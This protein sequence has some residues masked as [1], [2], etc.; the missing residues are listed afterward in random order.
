[1]SK[2]TEYSDG[3]GDEVKVVRDFLPPPQELAFQ[4]ERVKVK[5][6]GMKGERGRGTVENRSDRSV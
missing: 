3:P 1:M 6:G 4:E 2:G 5:M